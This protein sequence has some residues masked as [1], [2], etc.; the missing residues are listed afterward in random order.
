MVARPV[1]VKGEPQD[2][3]QRKVGEGKN[4]MLVFNAVRNEL[5]H[6]VCAVVRRG[7]TY[8]KNYTPTLA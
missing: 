3:C 7:E 4:K 6:R 8:D 5:I 1:C 2:Y